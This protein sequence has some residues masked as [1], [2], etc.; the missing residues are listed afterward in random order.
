MTPETYS[1]NL[2]EKGSFEKVH[3]IPLLET[4]T[5]TQSDMNPRSYFRMH[6]IHAQKFGN[7]KSLFLVL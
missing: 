6:S 4:L 7:S 5:P 3:A 2:I 1:I